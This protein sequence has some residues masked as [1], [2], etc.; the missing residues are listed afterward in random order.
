MPDC[1]PDEQTFIL[2]LRALP[3]ELLVKLRAWQESGEVSYV[4]HPK[5]ADRVPEDCRELLPRALCTFFNNC[6]LGSAVLKCDTPG[7]DQECRVI[8]SLAGVGL[9]SVQKEGDL[10]CRWALTDIGKMVVLVGWRLQEPCAVA[11]L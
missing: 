1:E 3:P 5:F 8:E 2:S 9:F 7:F 11:R 4:V 10:F 6:S